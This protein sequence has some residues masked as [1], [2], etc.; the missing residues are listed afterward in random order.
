MNNL[1]NYSSK[2]FPLCS[3]I[4]DLRIYIYIC[5]VAASRPARRVQTAVRTWA[6]FRPI[7]AGRG[8]V[9]PW[10]MIPDDNG[11]WEW[12]LGRWYIGV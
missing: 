1:K 9:K 4:Y 12:R 11:R 2:F 5:S 10:I 7:P 6:R 3:P 8:R